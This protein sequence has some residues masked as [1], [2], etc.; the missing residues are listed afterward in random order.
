MINQEELN[1]IH[2]MANNMTIAQGKLKK[3][4]VMTPED[5]SSRPYLNSVKEAVDKMTEDT[6]SRRTKVHAG[7]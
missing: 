4:L 7:G 1:Y 2:K 6:Q 3:L 5:A